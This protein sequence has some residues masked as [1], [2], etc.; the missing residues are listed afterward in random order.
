MSAPHRALKRVKQGEDPSSEI[1]VFSRKEVLQYQNKAL[2]SRLK[3]EI[4]ENKELTKK[5]EKFENANLGL[6]SIIALLYQQLFSVND[7]LISISNMKGISTTSEINL[8]ESCKISENF[9]L[10]AS[11]N[12]EQIIKESANSQKLIQEAGLNLS[13]L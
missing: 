12:L 2:A 11:T 6:L 1:E 7:K 13:K 3:I 4:A 8:R 10:F 9:T 5:N